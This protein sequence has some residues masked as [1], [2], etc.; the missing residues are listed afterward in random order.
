MEH[1][2]NI[3]AFLMKR[4]V[5]PAADSHLAERIIHA[6]LASIPQRMR[7]QSLWADFISM[8]A[9][10]HPAMLAVAGIILGLLVG[11]DTGD[12][13]FS[14]QQ[15]WASFLDVNEGGWL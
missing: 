4:A 8:F 7:P 10:P 1:D 11:L 2:K 6:A 12:G 14:L 13:L 15:D 3:D 9:I 5:P